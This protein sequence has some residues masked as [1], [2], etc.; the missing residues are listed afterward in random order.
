V[1]IGAVKAANYV[2]KRGKEGLTDDDR[3]KLA[4]LSPKHVDLTPA[5]TK[6]GHIYDAPHEHN[7]H[8]AVKQFD[9]LLEGENAVVITRLIRVDR[10]DKNE[11]LLVGKRGYEMKG[12]TLFLDCFMVDDSVSKPIRCRINPKNWSR[13][14]ELLADRAV[15]GQDWFLIRGRWLDKFSMMI[16]NKIKCLTNSEMF[17]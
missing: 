17:E 12:Q 4:K 6:W 16:V 15:A 5:H 2:Q 8:G 13:Y 11:K 9:E 10:R 14:G 3:K 7:I 1:G